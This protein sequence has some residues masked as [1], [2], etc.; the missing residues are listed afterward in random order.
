MSSLMK[1]YQSRVTNVSIFGN[2]ITRQYV[3]SLQVLKGPMVTNIALSG[4]LGPDVGLWVLSHIIHGDLTVSPHSLACYAQ[5]L[6]VENGR[7]NLSA[8]IAPEI[9]QSIRAVTDGTNIYSVWHSNCT[10]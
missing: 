2:G 4:F 1:E 8:P 9:M 3:P 5:M 7:P 6:S 10:K